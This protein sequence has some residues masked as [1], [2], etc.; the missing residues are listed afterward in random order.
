MKTAQ[1]KKYVE[2]LMIIKSNTKKYRLKGGAPAERIL[3]LRAGAP[4]C[5]VTQSEI[6]IINKYFHFYL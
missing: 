1:N 3:W 4:Y 6:F 2:K 5:T